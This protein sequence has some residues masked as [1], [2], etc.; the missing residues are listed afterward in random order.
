MGCFEGVE[1]VGDKLVYITFDPNF[2]DASQAP[3]VHTPDPM[4][5]DMRFTRKL[6]QCLMDKGLKIIGFDVNEMMPQFEPPA[7]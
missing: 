2:L 4:G 7:G 1:I 6:F 5:P 3:A